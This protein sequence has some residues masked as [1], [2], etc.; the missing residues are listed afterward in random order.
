[1][2]VIGTSMASYVVLIIMCL[3]S[4]AAYSYESTVVEGKSASN[5][6]EE[7]IDDLDENRMNN[8]IKQTF[9]FHT[10]WREAR[11][12]LS[13]ITKSGMYHK[14]L[15][16]DDILE[17]IVSSEME[18]ISEKNS[19]TEGQNGKKRAEPKVINEIINVAVQN[20]TY[21]PDNYIVLRAHESAVVGH[22][23]C[24]ADYQCMCSTM[25]TYNFIPDYLVPSF[26]PEYKRTY[27]SKI[28]EAINQIP[29]GRFYECYSLL[30]HHEAFQEQQ[31]CRFIDRLNPADN[32]KSIDS[33]VSTI[34]N[35]PF[36][37]K[38]VEKIVVENSVR[39]SNNKKLP[40]D[41]S[42][43]FVRPI[44]LKTSSGTFLFE[45]VYHDPGVRCALSKV[46]DNPI[47]DLNKCQDKDTCA[48]KAIAKLIP[49]LDR[50]MKGGK[51]GAEID[52]SDSTAPGER[53]YYRQYKQ[54]LVLGEPKFES[55][56]YIL[57]WYR[58]NLGSVAPPPAYSYSIGNIAH[59][60]SFIVARLQHSL[61]I[62]SGKNGPYPEGSQRDYSAYKQAVNDTLTKAVSNVCSNFNNAIFND[63]TCILGDTQ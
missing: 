15:V 5:S 25:N 27:I 3:L 23:D 60:G 59:E 57:R 29:D 16:A 63:G 44:Y 45:E 14:K 53:Y 33:I 52:R 7:I 34:N 32:Y 39:V 22:V 40:L 2:T 61:S 58:N 42:S 24:E 20:Y 48:S 54:S 10:Q 13:P 62:R 8:I 49:E 1:M 36:S 11:K 9:K 56:Q 35:A 4:S 26:L 38:D 47:F 19:A 43:R 28:L 12:P 51:L 37:A 41:K 18:R 30:N 17:R 6:A 31:Y 50:Q 46:F 55:S 21:S